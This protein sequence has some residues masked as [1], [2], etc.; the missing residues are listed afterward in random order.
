MNVRA[1]GSTAVPFDGRGRA[2]TVLRPRRVRRLSVRKVG[3]VPTG[4]GRSVRP[5]AGRRRLPARSVASRARPASAHRRRHLAA[6]DG[7]QGDGWRGVVLMLLLALVSAGAVLA[8]GMLAD[9]VRAAR[10]PE[11]AVPVVVRAH[12][13]LWQLAKRTAPTRE[14]AQVVRRIV[15]LNGLTSDSVRPGQVLMSPVEWFARPSA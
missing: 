9:L 1:I 10:V 2:S 11:P 12:E 3:P 4:P 6:L 7:W 14:P 15:E 13:S 8:L 5:V